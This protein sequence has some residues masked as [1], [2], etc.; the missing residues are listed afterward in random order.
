MREGG[1]PL[2]L[3]FQYLIFM[4][5]RA[6]G[7]LFILCNIIQSLIVFFLQVTEKYLIHYKKMAFISFL[8]LSATHTSNRYL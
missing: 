7:L 2:P 1:K 3:A 8:L 4:I 5:A 6:C